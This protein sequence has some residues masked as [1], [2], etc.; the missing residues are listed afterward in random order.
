ML[1]RR[2]LTSCHA[3]QFLT[4]LRPVPV[5]GLGVEDPCSKWVLLMLKKRGGGLPEIRWGKRAKAVPQSAHI[6]ESTPGAF[7]SMQRSLET[8]FTRVAA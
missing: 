6:G 7:E 3:A 1:A 8:A 5:R 4:G 2:P